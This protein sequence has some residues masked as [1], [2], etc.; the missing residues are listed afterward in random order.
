MPLESSPLAICQCVTTVLI[1]ARK[2]VNTI[3]HLGVTAPRS[4]YGIVAIMEYFKGITL[5]CRKSTDFITMHRILLDQ[6]VSNGAITANAE[7]CRYVVHSQPSN[8]TI[9]S[10][11]PESFFEPEGTQ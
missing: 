4:S 1:P 8:M 5:S 6:Q 7:L 10:F 9:T 11:F 3:D 2:P